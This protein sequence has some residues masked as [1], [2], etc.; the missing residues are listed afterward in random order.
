[1]EFK[2]TRAI[3]VQIA[4]RVSS[5]IL[6]GQF[7]A[8]ARLPSVRELSGELKVNPATVLRAYERLE[9]LG[10]VEVQRGIGYVVCAGAQELVRAEM[11]RE[12]FDEELPVL[13]AKLKALG[14]E[15]H[16]TEVV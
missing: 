13:Q 8:G 6:S 14:V 9:G 10:A 12:F 2:D 16:C 1:M 4:D 11:R 7:V 15:L 5:E 3:Y